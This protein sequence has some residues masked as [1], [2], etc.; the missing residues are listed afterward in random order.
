M[1]FTLFLQSIESCILNSLL[2]TFK[3]LIFLYA[4]FLWPAKC[5]RAEG[6]S[7]HNLKCNLHYFFAQQWKESDQ[8]ER[9]CQTPDRMCF[10][11]HFFKRIFFLNLHFTKGQAQSISTDGHWESGV[12]WRRLEPVVL[13]CNLVSLT[14]NEILGLGMLFMKMK[15]LN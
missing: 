1:S 5:F 11:S 12:W 15:G 9:C 3:N 4:F 10:P 2:I 6:I 13:P 7:K 14:C 8:N